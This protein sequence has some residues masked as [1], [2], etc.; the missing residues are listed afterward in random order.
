VAGKT[1]FQHLCALNID[2]N[3]QECDAR[4]LNNG[5]RPGQKQLLIIIINI[6]RTRSLTP[7]LHQLIK[8]LRRL[9]LFFCVLL[10]LASTAQVFVGKKDDKW[11][12]LYRET[13]P[14]I[15]DLVHTKLAVRFDFNKSYLYG[16]AWITLKPHFYVTDTLRLDAKGMNI[17]RVGLSTNGN[18]KNLEYTYDSLNLRIRLDKKYT[19]D[20]RY[21]IFIDY[22]AKPNEFR[23]AGSAAIRDAKGLYFINPLGKE[24]NK[25]TQV[26]TQGET[27]ASSVWFPTIDKT[28]QKSTSEISM[29]VPEKFV[30]LSNG[31]NTHQQNNPDGTRTDTWK[32]DLPHSPYLFFMGVGDFAV[33]KDS[34][35]G[36]EVSY[37]VEKPY[38]KVARKIFGLTPE[39]MK[40]FSVK[41][42]V[43]YPWAKYSQMTGRDY[44]SGAMENTT[45]TLHSD[46]LQQNARELAD[47]NKYEDYISHELFHQWFGDLVTAESWSNL[48][49]NESFANFSEILWLEH[50]YGK[51][52]A[53]EHNYKDL[54][55]YL[56]SGNASKDL[57]RF[58]YR[59]KE[60]M[61]DAVSYQKG[62]RILNML[63]KYVGEEAFF[64]S[65]NLYLN[66]YKFKN[67][68][69]HQLRLAFEQV[70]GQDLNWFF[71][72]WYFGSGHPQ[73]DISYRY[74]TTSKVAK[75]YMKQTQAG[76]VF[77]LPMAVDVYSNAKKTRFDVWMENK[78]DTFSFPSAKRPDLIN[79]DADK[80][81]LAKKTDAK[82]LYNYL[83]QYRF[84]KTYVDRREA[85]DYAVNHM[86]Q[87]EAHALV[88]EAL[89]DPFYELRERA[90]ANL[91]EETTKLT[92]NDILTLERIAV[93]DPRRT[94][95]SAAINVLAE[96]KD[97]SHKALFQKGA[98]DSSY[99]V[100]GASLLAL[101]AIDEQAAINL[102]PIV[103]K[104]AKGR[105]E[106][107]VATVAFLTKGDAD[108]NELTNKFDSTS[109]FDKITEY[110]LYLNF[111]GKVHNTENFKKGV[112]RIVEFRK[113]VSGLDTKY[114]DK[115]NEQL[116]EIIKK[117]QQLRTPQNAAS[118]DEQ[119]IYLQEK[120]KGN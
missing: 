111:L 62:G 26:W 93:N 18:I 7:T 76:K 23:A 28:D 60:D 108:F 87:A 58:Y 68:E 96:L 48:T 116:E 79:V 64:K 6:T 104:D 42:G 40:F 86:D 107:A 69:A 90:L 81:L 47:G 114:K 36:K 8:M 9:K 27:E 77:R 105:L 33:V 19:K 74:D 95:R 113:I 109:T 12:K 94:T 112:D 59:D 98:T 72:Q 51:D 120:I 110:N 52:A 38:E 83:Y 89:D 37:Y 35:K 97:Q 54:Q 45:A 101:A 80:I 66:T 39:M 82:T 14:K 49:L 17:N 67:A 44:V 106:K 119:I 61:F 78:A 2:M 32:M 65:L 30:T 10:P 3:V 70:T 13:V 41:L 75:V 118:M 92:K 63:R 117:K 21:T 99:T 103:E 56:N 4:M 91:V 55:A 46:Y 100:A 43:E 73:L 1:S 57:V 71:N 102:L 25:P 31:I 5:T 115:I 29:T 50:K 84:A 11:E 24:K 85:L 88:I 16:K 15:N 53:D 20:E 34:Y 22:T